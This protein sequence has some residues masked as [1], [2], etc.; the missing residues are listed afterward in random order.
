MLMEFRNPDM[1]RNILFLLTVKLNF[2]SYSM[3]LRVF[4]EHRWT[5]IERDTPA[6]VIG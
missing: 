3:L 2:V 6:F 1:K 4:K 5:E